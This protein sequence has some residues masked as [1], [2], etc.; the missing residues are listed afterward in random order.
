MNDA[1]QDTLELVTALA[2]EAGA[3]Q[4]ARRGERHQE[5]EKDGGGS[6]ATAVDLAR[7]QLILEALQRRFPHHRFIAEESGAAGLKDAEYTWVIDPLDG[8]ISYVSGQPY[9]AVSI[10]LLRGSA[11]VL[12]VVHLPAFERTYTVIRGDGAFRNGARLEVSRTSE[13]SLPK[14]RSTACRHL[15]GVKERGARRPRMGCDP[16]AALQEVTCPLP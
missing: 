13:R 3:L 16:T 8:T 2:R 4:L 14:E 15:F 12:G 5:L 7:E 10:G 6:F 1:A 9:F 11:P